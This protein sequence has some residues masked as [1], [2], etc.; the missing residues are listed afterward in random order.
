ML[1]FAEFLAAA[2]AWPGPTE[3]YDQDI[4]QTV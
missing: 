3:T 2:L 4:E 1:L